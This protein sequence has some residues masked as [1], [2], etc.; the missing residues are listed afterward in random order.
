[1]TRH[2]EGNPPGEG[3]RPP[4]A[5]LAELLED[6]TEDLFENA[7]CGYLST[8]PDGRI[9]RVNATLLAWLDTPEASWSGAATAPTC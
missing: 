5:D 6:S 1:M 7:P 3:A 2:I 4:E 9:A 8:F